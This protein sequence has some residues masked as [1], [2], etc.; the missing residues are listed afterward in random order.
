MLG[1]F[2]MFFQANKKKIDSAIERLVVNRLSSAVSSAS[3]EK[4]DAGLNHDTNP[5]KVV[6][7]TVPHVQLRQSKEIN[8]NLQRT[9]VD[10]PSS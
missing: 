5:I 8:S 2:E 9:H 7:N 6:Q 4:S 10:S 1:V 3:Y